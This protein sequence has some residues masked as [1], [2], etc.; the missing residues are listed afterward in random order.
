DRVYALTPKGEVVD[1]PMGATPL[2]F[3]YHVHTEVGHRCRG[4]KVNGRI[5]PLDHRLQSGDRVEI[6]TAKTGEPRRDWLVQS[7]GFLASSRSRE[8]VRNWFHKLDRGRNEAAGKDLLDRELRRLGLLGADLA[9]ARERFSLATDGDLHVL[10]GLGD[11]GPHQLGRV[12]LEHERAERA[13]AAVEAP[14][15][16][17]RSK[18]PRKQGDFTVE[19]VG[20]LLVQL[21]RCCQ[22]VPGEA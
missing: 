8:K 22:P 14:R 7:N 3:A 2:D 19:G 21:A 16:A 20:N 15:A 18:P 10:V 4:A 1:L 6:M 17:P 9:P 13:P 5:V 11:L 12:L